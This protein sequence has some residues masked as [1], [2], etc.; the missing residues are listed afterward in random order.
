[1]GHFAVDFLQRVEDFGVVFENALGENADAK[2]VIAIV[3]EVSGIG[4][5][6]DERLDERLGRLGEEEVF[7]GL[8]A[9]FLEVVESLACADRAEDLFG[10]AA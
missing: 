2:V 7:D 8:V 1:M 9:D 6:F 10:S 3:V 4:K 5:L